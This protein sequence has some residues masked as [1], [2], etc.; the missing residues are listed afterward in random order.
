MS[1]ENKVRQEIVEMCKSD[2]K[3]PS[4]IKEEVG[5]RFEDE[6]YADL[7]KIVDKQLDELDRKGKIYKE[8]QERYRTLD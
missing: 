5:R 3:T 7:R 4:E 6:V 2:S 1:L 8:E